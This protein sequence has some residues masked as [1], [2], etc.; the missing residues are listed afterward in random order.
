MEPTNNYDEKQDE[1]FEDGDEIANEEI[2]E[3][4]IDDEKELIY[5]EDSGYHNVD[6]LFDDQSQESAFYEIQFRIFDKKQNK[7][8]IKHHL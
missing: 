7:V 5:N 3:G 1:Y 2:N 8:R 4:E 6:K